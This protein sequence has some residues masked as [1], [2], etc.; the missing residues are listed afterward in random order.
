M[1]VCNRYFLSGLFYQHEVFTQHYPEYQGINL[2][3]V[4][5]YTLDEILSFYAK[6]IKDNAIVVAWSLAGI[7]SIL[8]KEK[9]PTKIKKLILVATSPKFMQFTDWSGI[10]PNELKALIELYQGNEN[11]FK[12]KF[13]KLTIY[14]NTLSHTGI[15]KY[16]N[17]KKYYLNY[18]N[19]LKVMDVRVQFSKLSHD[20]HLILGD[21]DVLM[22]TPRDDIR[23]V[24]SQIKLAEISGEGHAPFIT[25][26]LEFKKLLI[27][28]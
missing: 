20:C 7:F 22:K 14:P 18:L 16:I 3:E 15:S 13:S 12:N 6:N 11:I 27:A 2:P 28:Q 8:L 21:Q 24:N 17:T 10:S 1:D 25:N 19:L 26:V 23:K 9:F 5:N 4:S